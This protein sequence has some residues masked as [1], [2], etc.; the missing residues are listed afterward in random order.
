MEDSYPTY[1][2][3]FEVVMLRDGV[4]QDLALPDD[5]TRL[6]VVACDPTAAQRAPV[7]NSLIGFHPIG[8]T[9]PGALTGP[10]Q[11]ALARTRS[12]D[13]TRNW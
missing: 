5:F 10:E 3:P 6:H 7:V 9:P 2:Q 12:T 13:S 11:M 4:D 8:A 1:S